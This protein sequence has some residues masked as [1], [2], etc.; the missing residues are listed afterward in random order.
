MVSLGQNKNKKSIFFKL[1]E[2]RYLS[3]I[4]F[5]VQNQLIKYT[6]AMADVV[7]YV[8]LA[9][10]SNTYVEPP[11]KCKQEHSILSVVRR[12]ENNRIKTCFSVNVY[13]SSIN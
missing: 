11:S 5:M 4:F 7:D 12:I 8:L 3:Y 6:E 10:G 13:F 1:H 9:I 2:F